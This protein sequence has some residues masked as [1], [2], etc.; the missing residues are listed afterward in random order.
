MKTINLTNSEIQITLHAL[1]SW[2]NSLSGSPYREIIGNVMI[3][4][5]STISQV[6]GNENLGIIS[7]DTQKEEVA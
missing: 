4:L 7:I 6:F 3:K 5:N 1:N 2:V